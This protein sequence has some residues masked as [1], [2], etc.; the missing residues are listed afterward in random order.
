MTLPFVISIPHCSGNVPDEVFNTLA[1]S[2]HQV[3]ESVDF[4]TEEIFGAIPAQATVTAQW[5]R[6]VVDLNRDPRQ[7]DAKGVAALTDYHGRPIYQSE[8]APDQ[9]TIARRLNCFHQP[10]HDQLVSA[11]NRS[12]YIGLIDGHSLNGIGPLDAPDRGQKRKDVTLSNNGDGQGYERP[13][14]GPITCSTDHIRLFKQ[15]FEAQGFS[16]SL[17]SPYKGGYIANHYGPRMVQSGRFAIQIEMNQDLY[18]QPK[19]M[20]PEVHRI[21]IVTQQVMAALQDIAAALIEGS[22]A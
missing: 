5:S 15:C 18:M 16:V 2:R 21:R 14:A 22:L 6:L 20:A 1:L 3:L 9:A 4:G 10:Y 13:D 17:N 8:M 19:R 11:L 7:T 12:Q